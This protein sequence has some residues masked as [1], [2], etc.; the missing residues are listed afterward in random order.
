MSM[1][2]VVWE[3]LKVGSEKRKKFWMLVWITFHLWDS[4]YPSSPRPPT[5]ILAVVCCE[6]LLFYFVQFK[7]IFSHNLYDRQLLG[8]RQIWRSGTRDWWIVGWALGSRLGASIFLPSFASPQH[9]GW[10]LRVW[11]SSAAAAIH[12]AFKCR[13]VWATVF[14]FL[15]G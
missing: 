7:L 1:T 12:A 11:P 4:S 8:V 5:P 3:L 10:P 15:V 14:H 6:S 9:S 2:W 13:S